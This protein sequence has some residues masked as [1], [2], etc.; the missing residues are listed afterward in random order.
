MKLDKSKQYVLMGIAHNGTCSFEKYLVKL[1]YDVERSETAYNA[2]TI[3][4][5]HQLWEGKVPIFIYSDKVTKPDL[6]SYMDYW[7]PLNPV[8]FKLEK[9]AKEK[10]FP[11]ENEGNCFTQRPDYHQMK[12]D[13]L[14]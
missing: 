10:D 12:E 8:W 4:H 3:E 1:G 6:K 2:R 11:W 5:Y 14:L 7:K 9:L 13:N